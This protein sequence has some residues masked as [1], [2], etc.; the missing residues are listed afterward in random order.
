MRQKES[1]NMTARFLIKAANW[2]GHE[3]EPG[4][5]EEEYREVQ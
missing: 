5:Q 3:L 1:S 4:P 2:M